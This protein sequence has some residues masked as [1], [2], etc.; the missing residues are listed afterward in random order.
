MMRAMRKLLLPLFAA[1]VLFSSLEGAQA[2]PPAFDGNSGWAGCGSGTPWQMSFGLATSNN[3][4]SIFLII[5]TLG[6]GFGVSV[7]DTLGRTWHKR[8][9]AMDPIEQQNKQEEWYTSAPTAG[10]ATITIT[11]Q[12][13]SFTCVAGVAFGVSGA[14]YPTPFDPLFGGYPAVSTAGGTM[15]VNTLGTDDLIFVHYD[16]HDCSSPTV[17]AGWTAVVNPTSTFNLIQYATFGSA[18]T[19]L[20]IPVGSSCS[21]HIHNGIAEALVAA[22][23]L[24]SAAQMTKMVGLIAVA[25]GMQ[26]TKMVGLIAVQP[27]LST[28]KMLGLIAIKS[29]LSVNSPNSGLGLFHAFPP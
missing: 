2:T 19:G 9:Q 6:N 10:S 20:N 8:A 12:S 13:V 18:Q 25:P 17:G 16:T 26:V 11:M 24:G 22:D 15:N 1:L 4:D 7:T 23:G 3:N 27:G 21:S 14:A 5:G 28:S 29:Q